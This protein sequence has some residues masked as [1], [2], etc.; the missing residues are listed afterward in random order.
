MTW[1]A[2]A[3]PSKAELRELKRDMGAD[4]TSTK[5]NKRDDASGSKGGR[6]SPSEA[7]SRMLTKLRERLEVPDDGEWAVIADRIRQ[8]EEARRGLWLG[9]P[10]GRGG[11]AF[12]DKG[13]KGA[14]S[15]A[16]ARPEQDAL[17][18]AVNDNLTDAE[19]KARLDRAHEVHLQKEQ[20]LAK[21]QADLRAV[22]T[23]R[24]E[25]VAV[26]AGLLPP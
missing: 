25:A 3:K 9:A 18:S 2:A 15:G 19:I 1:L 21:T 8:V 14:R 20:Q 6:P 22:L 23:I 26:M 17:R 12:S 11:P 7:E 16:S 24:Q 13:K 4:T 10:G 5:D